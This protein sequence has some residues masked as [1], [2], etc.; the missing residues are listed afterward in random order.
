MNILKHQILKDLGIS[1]LLFVGLI[2]TIVIEGHLSSPWD[3]ITNGLWISGV[4]VLVFFM[5]RGFYRLNKYWKGK[6]E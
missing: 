2:F 3:R 6:R 5:G 4:I 1:W